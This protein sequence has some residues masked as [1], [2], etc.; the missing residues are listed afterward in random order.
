MVIWAVAAT[1][2]AI[3]LLILLL[4]YR[5]QVQRTCRHL[6]F[7]KDN[8][9][10]MKLTGESLFSEVNELTDRMNDILEQSKQI[11]RQ[12]KKGEEAFKE[13]ITNISHDIRTPLTSMDGYF[14]LLQQ[15][16]TREEREAYIAIIQERISCLN[17]MLEEL[18]TYT[19]LQNSQYEI[20]LEK[21]DFGKCVYDT[22]FSFYEECKVKGI[23]PIIDFSEAAFPV[24]GNT[25]AVKRA[26]QNVIK[27]AV[28]HGGEKLSLSL[29][30]EGKRV[31]FVCANSVKGTDKINT[32]KVFE[33]FYKSDT[34]RTHTSTGLGLS[35]AKGLIE[36]MGGSIKAELIESEGCRNQQMFTI[37]ISF[38]VL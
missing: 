26:L 4:T 37:Q 6:A 35:I 22:V 5:R 8:D 33:R 11:N 38:A 31:C 25:E 24:A 1:V 9:T 36:K 15:C 2:V 20:E 34:A 21:I 12:T 32:E 19:K 3:V 17:N 23:E 13:T 27:N 18:F 29:F 16:E 30:K 10:N 14:Q 7:I 28:E